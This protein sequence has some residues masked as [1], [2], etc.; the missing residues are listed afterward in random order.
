MSDLENA[1]RL[2]RSGQKDDAQKLLQSVIKGDPKNIQAW[3]WYV[4]TCATNEKRI[5]ALEMCLKFNPGNAQASNAL[6]KFRGDTRSPSSQTEPPKPKMSVEPEQTNQ[7]ENI[8]SY[9][10]LKPLFKPRETITSPRSTWDPP[11]LFAEEKSAN[12]SFEPGLQPVFQKKPWELDPSEYEDNS[13]LSRK[14]KPVQTYSALDV[15]ATVLTVQDSEAYEE[16]LKDPKAT[17]GRAFGWVALAGLVSAIAFPFMLL[18]NPQITDITSSPEFR[19]LNASGGGTAF[20]VFATF[21]MLIFAPIVG[22]IN[23]AITGGVQNLTAGF[24][25]GTGNFTRTVYALAAYIAPITM[26]VALLAIVPVV[27]QCVAS[28]LGFYTIILNIRALRAA[29]SLSTGAALG[30]LLA[31]GLIVMIFACLLAFLFGGA[32]IPQM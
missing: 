18:V 13:M 6:Q 3:F 7:E 4:E 21:F 19:S 16:I 17:L 28:L 8:Y 25:G 5:Q 30:A 22:I 26:I 12:E 29:H 31:P 23:L 24:L 11:A 20:L 1:I 15:W 32:A 9:D 27:G 2:I 10:P 14:K